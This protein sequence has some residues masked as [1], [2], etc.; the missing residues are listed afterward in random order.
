MANITPIVIIVLVVA[1]ALYRRMMPQPVRPD[2]TVV[3]TLIIVVLAA[4]SLLGADRITTHPLALVLALP[5]LVVGF[6][7]GL[8]LMR[9]IHFW[10]D[11]ATGALWM[12]GG[13]VYLAVWLATVALRLIITFAAGTGAAG[14][15]NPARPHVVNPAL[16]VLSADLVIVSIGLW[17]ARAVA[18]VRA[19]R[20]HEGA[21][22]PRQ[23]TPSPTR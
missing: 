10:R 20:A 15:G 3:L 1:F 19:Y 9:S 5:A 2:R 14:A 18:L 12:K 17:I 23:S 21:D 4:S 11:A 8:L 6:G 7:G 22:V 13:V 16:A